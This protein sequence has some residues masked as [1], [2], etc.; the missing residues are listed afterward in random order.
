MTDLVGSPFRLQGRFAAAV[1]VFLAGTTAA[2][3]HVAL[4]FGEHEIA[5]LH[6]DRERLREPFAYHAFWSLLLD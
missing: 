6:A 1:F 3:I 4:C 5:L 2:R